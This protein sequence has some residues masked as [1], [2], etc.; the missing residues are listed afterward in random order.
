MDGIANVARQQQSQVGTQEAQG[1][2]VSA[3]STAGSAGSTTQAS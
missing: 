1:R 3:S 2:A